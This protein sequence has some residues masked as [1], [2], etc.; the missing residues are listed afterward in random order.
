MKCHACGTWKCDRCGTGIPGGDGA[1]YFLPCPFGSLNAST[2]GTV[3]RNCYRAYA[4]LGFEWINARVPTEIADNDSW[5]E[6]EG[7]QP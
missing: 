3:C 1:P 7:C 2:A 6:V 5:P 4:I